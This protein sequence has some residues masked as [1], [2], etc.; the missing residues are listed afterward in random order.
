MD[1][2]FVRLSVDEHICGEGEGVGEQPGVGL[3]GCSSWRGKRVQ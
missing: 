2:V 1:A 3:Q